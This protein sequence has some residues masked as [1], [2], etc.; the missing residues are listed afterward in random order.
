[1]AELVI[2]EAEVLYVTDAYCGWCYGFGPTLHTFYEANRHRVP[3]RVVS[4]G[5][6]VGELRLPIRSYGHI[7]EVNAR[8]VRR[9]GVTFGDPYKALLREGS[10][11]QDSAAAA[12]GLAALRDQAP[13]LSIEFISAM[14]R[15]FYRDGL[16][17][18]DAATLAMIARDY[19]LDSERVVSFF[20]GPEGVAAAQQDFSFAR[21]LGVS[22]YPTLLVRRG[23]VVSRL[24][25]VGNSPAA[26][27]RRL[28]VALDD[29]CRL[30]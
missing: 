7:E 8:I 21:E 19:G 9:M 22:S 27:T 17:L 23:E 11:V 25:S 10:F 13:D 30:A 1:M 6:F 20:T 18:S 28:D 4:G 16:N 3:F 2:P 29:M 26:L 24:P 5:L 14:Q 12:A 15:A